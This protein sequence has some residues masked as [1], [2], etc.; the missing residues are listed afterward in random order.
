A[1]EL[2]IRRNDNTSNAVFKLPNPSSIEPVQTAA[3]VS[4]P[5]A[6]AQ[7]FEHDW[8]LQ[9]LPG[10]PSARADEDIERWATVERVVGQDSGAEGM[11]PRPRGLL[12]NLPSTRSGPLTTTGEP[13]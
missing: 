6:R 1:V 10:A 2:K 4:T 5:G 13:S 11:P 8:V 3:R 9:L 7:P 12:Y